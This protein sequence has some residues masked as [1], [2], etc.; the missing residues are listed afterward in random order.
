MNLAPL[1][2]V[3]FDDLITTLTEI[4]DGYVLSPERFTDPLDVVEAYRYVGQLLSA[5][6]EMFFEADTAHP[7]MAP[8]VSPARKVQGDNP[9]A[10]YHYARIS[11][12][13]AYRISGVIDQECYTSFTIHGRAPDGALAGPLLGDVNDRDFHVEADGSY[14]IVLSAE[15][16]D[17]NWLRLDPA[18]H[19][20]VVR[21]YFQ[22]QRSAQN[23]PGV[24]VNI[25]IEPLAPTPPSPPLSDAV[26]AERMREGL[27]FL[28]QTTLGQRLPSV[29]VS[30]P[31]IAEEPNTLPKPFSF[32]DSGLPVPGAADIFYAS[33]R[34]E[35]GDDE[36]LVIAGSLPTCAF[37]NVML[38]NRHMQTLEYSVR[39]SSINQEQLVL[40]ADGSFRIVVAHS[41]PGV[42]NWLDTEGHAFG[43]IF[44]RILLPEEDPPQT[45]CE[46]VPLASLR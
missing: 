32:R 11:G 39:R 34:W 45:H 27:E 33:G 38:W 12:D 29:K 24:H 25:E 17:G 21:S 41:D 20:V 19:A 35:L 23:D 26:F 31:F 42:P 9:D 15:P 16:H 43:T 4:R 10:I 6:S 3:V 28:R 46:V 8:I 14:S 22:L 1:T 30:I 13:R 40:E 18:A 2:T 7:R 36:A 44:W 37:A 5:A